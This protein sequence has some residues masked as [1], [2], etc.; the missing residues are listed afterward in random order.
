[1]LYKYIGKRFPDYTGK[2][3]KICNE[4][5]TGE[6]VVSLENQK[7]KDISFWAVCFVCSKNELEGVAV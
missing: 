6:V 3:V 4:L 2:F 1:M 5:I 7:S